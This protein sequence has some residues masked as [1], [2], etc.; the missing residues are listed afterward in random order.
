MDPTA[1]YNRLRESYQ[2][3]LKVQKDLTASDVYNYPLEEAIA[4]LSLEVN[5][6]YQDTLPKKQPQTKGVEHESH[7]P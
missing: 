4:E 7:A 2:T 1:R 5:Q 3:L 6:A